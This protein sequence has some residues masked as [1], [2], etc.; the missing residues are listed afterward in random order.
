[1]E[2]LVEFL[3]ARVSALEKKQSELEQRVKELEDE[4]IKNINVI[5]FEML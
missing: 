3:K 2:Q 4:K 5:E 1:M